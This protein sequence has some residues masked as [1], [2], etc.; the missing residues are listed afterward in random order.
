MGCITAARAKWPEVPAV[1]HAELNEIPKF[2]QVRH[3][4]TSAHLDPFADRAQR[5]TGFC[6]KATERAELN[7]IP[8]FLHV[9]QGA[10]SAHFGP[11]RRPGP[12]SDRF[13]P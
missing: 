1:R 4:A 5:L 7:E 3:G 13:L 11:F 12:T 9:R 2:L 6:R 10:A 8:K